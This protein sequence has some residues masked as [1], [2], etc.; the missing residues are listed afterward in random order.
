LW[1]MVASRTTSCV[2]AHEHQEAQISGFCI[3]LP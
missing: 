2:Y 1:K 3:I